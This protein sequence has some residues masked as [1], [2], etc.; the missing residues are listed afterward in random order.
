MRSALAPRPGSC[1]SRRSS[2]AQVVGQAGLATQKATRDWRIEAEVISRPVTK[3]VS[4]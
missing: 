3:P 4:R 2:D 1:S